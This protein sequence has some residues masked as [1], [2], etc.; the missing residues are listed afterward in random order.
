MRAL[1]RAWLALA[2]L[3]SASAA[4]AHLM[5]NSAIYL[6]FGSQSIAAEIVMPVSELEYAAGSEL[7]LAPGARLTGKEAALRG[8]L[9]RHFAVRADDGRLWS[10]RLTDLAMGSDAWGSD[11]R[12]RVQLTPP[13]GGSVR[14]F[15]LHYDAIID[16]VPNH[17]VLLFA[18]ADY[19]SGILSGAPEMI[20]GLQGPGAVMLVDRGEGSAWRGF[21]SAVRLGM[22]HIAEGHDHLLFLIALILPAPLLARGRRWEAYGGWRHMARRLVAVVTAFTIGHS[23]TLIGGAFLGWQL[24]SQPVEILIALSIL[25]SAVH[26]WRPLFAGREALI[27]GGFGLVHGLAFATLIG[28]FGLEPLQKAQSI[29]GFNLGIEIVQLAVVA[30]VLPSLLIFGR[31]AVYRRLRIGGAL[32]AGVAAVAWIVERT[33]GTRNVLGEAIDGGLAHSP[34]LLLALS[35][36][37]IAAAWVRRRAGMFRPNPTAISPCGAAAGS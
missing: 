32:F 26:A 24:P 27:A 16:R 9:L 28:N 37:A 25:V 11:L 20:G 19:R 29:L 8:F 34:W 21:G 7:G 5:P 17:F 1:A 30:A 23:L 22:K 14:R 10:V 18:R 6:D 31:M 3:F 35:V 33:V 36:A 13:P 4:W 15:R 12:V 2:L